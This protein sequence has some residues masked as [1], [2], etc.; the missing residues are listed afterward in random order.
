MVDMPGIS[1]RTGQICG[2][3]DILATNARKGANRGS[4]EIVD[5][6]AK[7]DNQA[8]GWLR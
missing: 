7:A 8:E 4:A 1:T 5:F 6:A 3:R 2:I